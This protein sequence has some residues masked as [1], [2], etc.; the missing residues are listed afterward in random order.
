MTTE[1]SLVNQLAE[2][3]QTSAAIKT[4][5]G[6]PITVNSRTIIPVARVMYGFGAGSG[7][8]P[9]HGGED[10]GEGGG[11]GGGVRVKPMGVIEISDNGTRFI[12]VVDA[13]RMAMYGVVCAF[14]FAGV[15]RAYIRYLIRRRR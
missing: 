6:D 11:G 15:L 8:G 12:P 10:T 4:V 9:A 14:L 3:F 7:R 2:R 13:G 5:Y 1:S